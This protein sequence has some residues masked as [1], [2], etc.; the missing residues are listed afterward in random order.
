M[1]A[2]RFESLDYIK[3]M[4]KKLHRVIYITTGERLEYNTIFHFR[5]SPRIFNRISANN[6]DRL[7][8][9]VGFM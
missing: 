6:F 2:K 5:N 1:G 4:L 7:M 9:P 8:I 3:I